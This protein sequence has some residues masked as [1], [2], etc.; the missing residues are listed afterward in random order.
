MSTPQPFVFETGSEVKRYAPAT[1][2][3]RDAIAEALTKLLPDR[4]LVLEISSGTGEHAVHFAKLFPALT[5]QPTDPD[6]IAVASIEAWRADE[7]V[8]NVLPAMLLDAASDWPVAQANAVLCIN[9]VHISP[10]AATLG[11]LRNAARTLVPS[12]P[13]CIYGPFRQRDVVLADS[14]AAFDASLRQQNPE[15]GL[16]YV[17]D[18]SKTASEAGLR[19]DEIVE[20]PANNL[21]L[22]FRA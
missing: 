15:W 13:L 17:E 7:N 16:R 4:G 22:V 10:W 12:S 5:W 3:N 6:P 21:L 19:L 8:A 2:R 11:L 20:M 18:M 9:M 14:N 1:V